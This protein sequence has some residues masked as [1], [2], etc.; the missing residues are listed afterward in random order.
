MTEHICN[1]CE[2]CTHCL[3]IR[4][5]GKLRAEIVVLEDAMQ[6][7]SAGDVSVAYEKAAVLAD[8]QGETMLAEQIRSLA[9][10][11]P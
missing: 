9:K 11:S 7:E 2:F 1:D 4:E 8:D 10:E 6:K 5:V 3:L